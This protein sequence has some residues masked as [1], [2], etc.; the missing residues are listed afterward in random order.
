[1]K[2]H[3]LI[4][5]LTFAVAGIAHAAGEKHDH[6]HEPQQNAGELVGRQLLVMREDV[7]EEDA[8]H[9]GRG[10]EERRHAPRH[11]RLS[12][13]HEQVRKKGVHHGEGEEQAPLAPVCRQP[14]AE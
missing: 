5:T 2:L 11:P 7:G 12:P 3:T 10:I 1:M 13:H 9:G 14:V 4:A 6:A 8:E